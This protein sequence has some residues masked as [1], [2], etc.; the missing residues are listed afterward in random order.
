MPSMNARGKRL[1]E[2]TYTSHID[3]LPQSGTYILIISVS[4]QVTINVGGLGVR[5]LPKGYYSYT[6]SALGKGST[7]LSNRISRH[8]RNEK[9]NRWHIDFLL[10][11]KSSKVETVFIISSDE[12]MECELNQLLKNQLKAKVVVP[13]FG[14]SDCHKRCKSHLLF[15]PK[16]MRR[17]SLIG[18]IAKTLSLTDNC[19]SINLTS[20]RRNKHP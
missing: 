20:A 10:G 15:F 3:N 7:S 16:I 18:D 12:R 5:T 2:K 13:S 9:A 6:G 17:A 8:L 4:S 11:A 19:F 1:D 14:A